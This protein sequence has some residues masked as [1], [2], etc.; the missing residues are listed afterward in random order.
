MLM[1]VNFTLN[2]GFSEFVSRTS[3]NNLKEYVKIS[4][5]FPRAV[6][7]GKGLPLPHLL[8]LIFVLISI[9]CLLVLKACTLQTAVTHPRGK[10]HH[11]WCEA[12]KT[13]QLQESTWRNGLHQGQATC[14]MCAKWRRHPLGESHG[15]SGRGRAVQQQ[16]RQ[17]VEHEPA[18]W[19]GGREQKGKHSR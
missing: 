6:G 11:S 15:R 12:S 1:S 8:L 10:R 19:V 13:E 5:L 4:T 17:K 18:N 16:I 2:C 3:L 14:G 7:T 9:C